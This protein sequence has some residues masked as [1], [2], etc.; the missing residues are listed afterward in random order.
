MQIA[1]ACEDTAYSLLLMLTGV[2]LAD[3]KLMLASL[4]RGC[5]GMAFTAS[6]PNDQS[7]HRLGCSYRQGRRAHLLTSSQGM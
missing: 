1:I 6:V 7:S 5:I 3:P 4:V 2:I